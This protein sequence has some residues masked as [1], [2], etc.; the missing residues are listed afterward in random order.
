MGSFSR[1]ITSNRNNLA[2][3]RRWR[4]RR[5]G[6]LHH[7]AEVRHVS[8]NVGISAGFIRIRTQIIPRS[9]R[10]VVSI[11]KVSIVRVVQRVGK[12]LGRRI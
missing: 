9:H 10:S 4:G 6:A 3:R 11:A 1:A 5:K 12:A 8:L 2:R 7:R